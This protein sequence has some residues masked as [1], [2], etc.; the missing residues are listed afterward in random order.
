MREPPI[1]RQVPV[2]YTLTLTGF[3]A[4]VAAILLTVADMRR[5]FLL[6]PQAYAQLAPPEAHYVNS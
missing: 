2:R 4:A 5:G 6:P 3:L 1:A